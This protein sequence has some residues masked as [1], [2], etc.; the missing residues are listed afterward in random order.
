MGLRVYVLITVAALGLAASLAYLTWPT[1]FVTPFFSASYQNNLVQRIVLKVAN[2]SGYPT[3]FCASIYG[4]LP[5]ESFMLLDV[6]CGLGSV[7]LNKTALRRYAEYWRGAAGQ[8]GVFVFLTYVNGTKGGSYTLGRAVKGFLIDPKRV[9]AGQ[10]LTATIYVRGKPPNLPVDFHF[11]PTSTAT[12]LASTQFQSWPP[13]TIDTGYYVWYLNTVY[14]EAADVPVP[15]IVVR[16]A[17]PFSASMI[18][19]VVMKFEVSTS[20]STEIYFNGGAEVVY[21][22]IIQGFESDIYSFSINQNGQTVW[23]TAT[24]YPSNQGPGVAAVGFYGDYAIANYTEYEVYPDGRISPTGYSAILYVIRP[25]G[26][27]GIVDYSEVDAG[28]SFSNSWLNNLMSQVSA[29]WTPEYVYGTGSSLWADSWTLVQDRQGIPILS[30][31]IPIV[32][33]RLLKQNLNL[34]AGLG[35]DISGVYLGYT[36]AAFIYGVSSQYFLVG[37]YYIPATKYEYYDVYYPTPSMFIDIYV[38]EGTT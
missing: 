14:A 12:A 15:V 3:Y 29:Y 1:T 28:T 5:N 2:W 22:G 24:Y 13:P 25:T 36:T 9:L 17:D 23:A 35:A 31:A 21:N 34:A 32:E 6:K 16:V 8:I 37:K 33:T 27:G 38:G 7:E 20:Q 30:L 18:C 10:S 11:G 19:C 26:R 4:W